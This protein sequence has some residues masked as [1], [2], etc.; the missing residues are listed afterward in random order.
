MA[1]T[2]RMRSGAVPDRDARRAVGA[3]FCMGQTTLR[4]CSVGL[5]A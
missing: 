3:C 5:C 4:H 2:R 1:S